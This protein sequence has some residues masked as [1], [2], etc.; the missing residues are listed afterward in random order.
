L[1]F[2]ITFFSHG[3]ISQKLINTT[4]SEVSGN[5]FV[6]ITEINEGAGLSTTNEP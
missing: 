1:A 5:G 2:A 4:N 3:Q 6:N